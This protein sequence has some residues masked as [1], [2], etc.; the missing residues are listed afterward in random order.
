M[1]SI[2]IVRQGVMFIKIH[3]LFSCFSEL[4][5]LAVS[6]WRYPCLGVVTVIFNVGMFAL[7]LYHNVKNFANTGEPLV[8]L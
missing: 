8:A 1:C 6:S 5:T 4:L 7:L 2:D 3:N